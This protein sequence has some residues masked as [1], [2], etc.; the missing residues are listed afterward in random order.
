MRTS[1]AN[2]DQ[3]SEKQA[4]TKRSKFETRMRVPRH[5]LCQKFAAQDAALHLNLA[6]ISVQQYCVTDQGS[7]HDSSGEFAWSTCLNCRIAA[8]WLLDTLG[9][10]RIP[11]RLP[12]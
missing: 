12:A 11:V 8:S 4:D 2:F 1:L 7:L 3:I 6:C 5:S 9:N 10:D